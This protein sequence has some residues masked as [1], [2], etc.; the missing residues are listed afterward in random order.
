M[1]R[2]EKLRLDINK[3]DS[4]N[5]VNFK[6]NDTCD[7]IIDVYKDGVVQDVSEQ[8]I[9]FYVKK[10]DSTFVEQTTGIS[11]TGNVVTI[12]VDEQVVT[13]EGRAYGEITLKDN[14]GK[15]TSSCFIINIGEQKVN[16]NDLVE[17]SDKIA[18]LDEIRDFIEQAKK[19]IA[20]Y[21]A[22]I[23]DLDERVAENNKKINE[24]NKKIDTV[25][26]SIDETKE[27]ALSEIE[28]KH[29][30]VVNSINEAN[31]SIN[32][33]KG[34][35]LSDI[36]AE[37]E[38][39][40]NAINETKT[41]AVEAISTNIN[42]GLSNIN[43]AVE[44]G[45]NNIN[46]S[47]NE[48]LEE[49]ETTKE[50][51]KELNSTAQNTKLQLKGEHSTAE[52]RRKALQ[53][54]VDNANAINELLITTKEEASVKEINL[55][56]LIERVNSL[57]IV[58]DNNI[59]ALN[60]ENTKAES[61]I[62]EINPLNVEA[63]E[64]IEELKR[65]IQQAIDIAIPALK[66]YIA[67]HTPAEDLTEVN[68]QLEELFNAV[69]ELDIRFNNYYTKEET[70]ALISEKISEIEFPE[71]DLSNYY[72]KQESE[73][74]ISEKI[75]MIEFPKVDLSNY[76]TK[77]EVYNKDD[78][79]KKLNGIIATGKVGSDGPPACY[80]NEPENPYGDNL[81]YYIRF[82]HPDTN[83]PRLIYVKKGIDERYPYIKVADT[84]KKS[85]YMSTSSYITGYDFDGT[86]W[87][88]LSTTGLPQVVNVDDLLIYSCSVDI[89]HRG[90]VGVEDETIYHPANELD[91]NIITDYNKAIEKKYYT[92]NHDI[93]IDNSPV[94]SFMGYIV[95]DFINSD[96]LQN[97]YN[98]DNELKYSRAKVNG[99]WGEWKR[100]GSVDLS[101]YY[102]K[103]EVDEVVKNVSVDLSDYYTKKEI[104][105]KIEVYKGEIGYSEHN[106]KPVGFDEA[107]ER[108][109]E[110]VAT[111][112][113]S[114][115]GEVVGYIQGNMARMLNSSSADVRKPGV[116][117]ITN[118]N[119]QQEGIKPT[120]S[121]SATTN[122]DFDVI[123]M[124]NA[125]GSTISSSVRTSICYLCYYNTE[126]G[127]FE[128]GVNP[129]SSY[130]FAFDEYYYSTIDIYNADNTIAYPACEGEIEA[131][132]PDLNK[133]I[134]E[135][136]YKVNIKTGDVIANTPFN[137]VEDSNIA[138]IPDFDDV[139]ASIKEVQIRASERDIT[140]ILKV[141]VAKD[142]I[143][144]EL[145]EDNGNIFKRMFIRGLWTEWSK[146]SYLDI[147]PNQY[148]E[149]N[150]E[151]ITNSLIELYNN[152][153]RFEYGEYEV[154]S[155]KNSP[156]VT[157]P[158]K[159]Y[160]DI[161][162]LKAGGFKQVLGCMVFP[163]RLDFHYSMY[164]NI[165]MVLVDPSNKP[166]CLRLYIGY[167]GDRTEAFHPQNGLVKIKYCVFGY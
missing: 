84:G 43:N 123:Q 61:N 118:Y 63:D 121:N 113:T 10:P 83:C 40:V 62:N 148:S 19:D 108:L 9:N 104:D 151:Y 156:H 139:F 68:K 55:S 146:E 128:K 87:K 161:V 109:L 34:Q 78:I 144:Q 116:M 64:N 82:L 45:L 77:E 3:E 167:L 76:Y 106:V 70:N 26:A 101:G 42:E 131:K 160:T 162:M 74:L 32:E 93:A 154:D 1:K 15:M 88:N 7:L 105:R 91:F 133:C 97:L 39:S 65:L 29:Q 164:C 85:L 22:T 44:E 165:N 49:L 51:L 67:E 134:E 56:E 124:K 145:I 73:A 11:A 135:G 159:E 90:S 37:K 158:Q 163:H 25:D 17:S 23:S 72:N 24:L 142:V 14:N 166:D 79:N 75:G 125:S 119:N 110:N 122:R 2:I 94:E 31:E 115:K 126:T 95:N 117:L 18:I 30:E 47:A 150:G 35:A 103:E 130:H 149:K 114:I 60:V 33:A 46:N 99:I 96:I 6:Q 36:N 66:A 132:I 98:N 112:H 102:T 16:I 54:V 153:L 58:A 69:N 129:T 57:I 52:N 20:E 21:K 12:N 38:N 27:Q 111:I 5:I 155:A 28:A 143:H 86:N 140:G 48:T 136:N 50:E 147:E 137:L 81:Y 107:F 141:S 8:I 100:G 120:I 71:T 157:N 59:S 92:V 41:E 80:L 13:R 89:K 138:L 152:N 127:E 4:F 53:E